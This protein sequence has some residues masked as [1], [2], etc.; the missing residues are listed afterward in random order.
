MVEVLFGPPHPTQGPATSASILLPV[1][2]A[3]ARIGYY[4]HPEQNGYRRDWVVRGDDGVTYG[5][6]ARGVEVVQPASDE[7][8]PPLVLLVLSQASYLLVRSEKGGFALEH[9]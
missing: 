8:P 2:P 6:G 1:A 9:L 4:E 3:A 5:R 7:P